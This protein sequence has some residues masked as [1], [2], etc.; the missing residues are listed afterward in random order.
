MN[1]GDLENHL[2][3]SGWPECYYEFVVNPSAKTYEKLYEQSFYDDFKR[4]NEFIRSLLGSG[5]HKYMNII[6]FHDFTSHTSWRASM[7]LQVLSI[8]PESKMKY[9]KMS[10][11]NCP[12]DLWTSQKKEWTCQLADEARRAKKQQDLVWKPEIAEDYNMI[13][14]MF[15]YPIYTMKTSDTKFP[16]SPDWTE[17]ME[18]GK[19]RFSVSWWSGSTYGS[20]LDKIHDNYGAQDELRSL[21]EDRLKKIASKFD[22]LLFK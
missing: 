9:W 12:V 5:R 18:R 4:K 21:Y 6:L 16:M 19:A 10:H 17:E 14:H 22:E 1:I 15:N 11:Y 7:Y 13:W 2:N 20:I 3:L 8:D